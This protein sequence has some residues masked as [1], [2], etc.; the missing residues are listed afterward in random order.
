MLP[1]LLVHING[2]SGDVILLVRGIDEGLQDVVGFLS[3]CPAFRNHLV[4]DVLD[5]TVSFVPLPEHKTF[6]GVVLCSDFFL[7]VHPLD[8]SSRR[9]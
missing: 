5:L 7:D 3:R 4:E 8:S 2:D 1:D 9:T 6:H